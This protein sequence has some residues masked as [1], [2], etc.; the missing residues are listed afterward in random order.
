MAKHLY[1]A[2]AGS[3]KTTSMLEL[4]RQTA[5]SLQAEVRVC[6]PPVCRPV[7]GSDDWPEQG[8]PSVSIFSSLTGW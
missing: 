1:L 3:G 8:V 5:R 2:P 7:P 4:A 6:V